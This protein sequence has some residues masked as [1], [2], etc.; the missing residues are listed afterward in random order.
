MARTTGEE[1]EAFCATCP[2][3]EEVTTL[4]KTFG[5]ELTF[6]LDIDVSPDYEHLPCLPAQFHF[7]DEQGNEVLFLAGRD[8]DFDGRGFPEHASR[9]WL[10]AGADR[11]V[12]QRVARALADRWSFA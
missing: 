6:H 8:V 10:Y 9:F 1:L 7:Q 2:S 4:L 11:A 3:T 12:Y 5:L